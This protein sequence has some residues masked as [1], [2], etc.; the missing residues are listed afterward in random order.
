MSKLDKSLLVEVHV[1]AGARFDQLFTATHTNHGAIFLDAL[2]PDGT[3]RSYTLTEISI[4]P[5]QL[6]WREH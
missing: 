6:S 3:R 4:D 2:M 1:A 5:T